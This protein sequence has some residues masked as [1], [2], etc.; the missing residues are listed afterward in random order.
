[1]FE[2]KDYIITVAREGSISKAAKQLYISQPSLSASVKRIEEKI[3]VPLFDRTTTPISL[4]EAGREYLKYALQIKESERAFAQYVSD[5]YHILAGTVKIGG[6]S[7]FSSFMIPRM[8]AEFHSKY[9][10]IDFEIFE[11][12]TEILLEKLHTGVLDIVID[13]AIIKDD[14]IKATVLNTERLLLAV[15]ESF[16]INKKLREFSM[17]AQDVKNGI[18]YKC[19]QG[20]SLNDFRDEPFILL[21]S[22]NDTGSRA[23]M[24]FKKH[25]ITP[26]VRFR[27]DQQLTAFNI[28]STGIGIS[29]VSDTLIK[30]LD[31]SPRLCYYCLS[32]AE[33]ERNVFFY[34]KKNH[35]LSQV[36]QRFIEETLKTE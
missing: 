24:L 36:C 4:T 31:S 28:S 22:G 20:V 17:T 5:H 16:S 18:D 9:S 34:V 25:K 29:F 33:T 27:L 3:S 14:L 32:D 12:S 15:P 10:H 13:N 2:N 6:S 30:H 35:Y 21:N 11:N 19:Q 23:E 26:K 8:V 7:F 1:M